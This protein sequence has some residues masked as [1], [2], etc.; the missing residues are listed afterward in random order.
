MQTN[1]SKQLQ[2]L[3]EQNNISLVNIPNTIN[4]W[5]IRTEGGDL[6]EEFT[7][8]NFIAMGWNDVPYI[9]ED[10]ITDNLIKKYESN[11]YTQPRRIINQVRKFYNEIKKDD[12]IIIPSHSSKIFSFGYITDEEVYVEKDVTILE[13]CNYF[14]RRKINWVSSIPKNKIDPILISFLRNQQAISNANSKAAY[15]DRA[16]YPLYVKNGIAHFTLD[17]ET[18]KAPN[19]VDI[20]YY[21]LGTLNRTKNILDS[22]P[23]FELKKIDNIQSKINVQSPGIIE[24]LGDPTT[25]L[26]TCVVTIMLFGGKVKFTINSEEKSGEVSTNGLA[27]FI[28]KIYKLHIANRD[29]PQTTMKKYIDKLKIKNPSKK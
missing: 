6:Y 1:I 10:D 27:G 26:L 22:Y 28:I 20:P 4:Y 17:V 15:I 25:I 18:E 9:N 16:L 21:L 19:A 12:L 23:E 2:N 5:F 11:G 7:K 29:F 13:S 8:N 24:L 14:K 3:L